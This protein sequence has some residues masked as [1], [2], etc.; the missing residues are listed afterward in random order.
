MTPLV[1][2]RDAW[3]RQ[4]VTDFGAGR[5]EEALDAFQA[6]G[7]FEEAP[8]Y[9]ATLQRIVELWNHASVEHPDSS[10][11]LI[12][13]T[14]KQVA[15]VSQSVR[16]ELKREGSIMAQRPALRRLR[17][18]D[19]QLVLKSRPATKSASSFATISSASSTARLRL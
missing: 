5:A 1:R 6:H 4:A 10:T 3:A 12:A 11:L 18:R 17:H 15:D 16:A 13:R 19:S 14:N 2:Q 8:S 9:R 7:C